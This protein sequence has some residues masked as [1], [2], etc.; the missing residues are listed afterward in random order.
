MAEIKTLTEF[1][2]HQCLAE[3]TNLALVYFTAPYCSACHHLTKVLQ[4]YLQSSNDND[5]AIFNVDAGMSMALVNEFNVFHLPSMF[6]YQHGH[7][8]CQLHAEP[9]PTAITQAIHRA[10]QLPAEEEP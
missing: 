6:L 4:Q 10:L 9:L 7:Y 1:D 5:I 8:H 2:Y 3:T